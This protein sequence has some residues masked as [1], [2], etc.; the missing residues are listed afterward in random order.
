MIPTST[1][2]CSGVT[3]TG[4]KLP[5]MIASKK[6]NKRP[7]DFMVVSVNLQFRA[8]PNPNIKDPSDDN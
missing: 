4:K 5:V 6:L 8:K 7:D 2:P 1:R 3:V